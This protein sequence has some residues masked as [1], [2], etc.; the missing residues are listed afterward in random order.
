MT[1]TATIARKKQPENKEKKKPLLVVRSHFDLLG[2]IY[3]YPI[4]LIGGLGVALLF[5]KEMGIVAGTLFGVEGTIANILAFIILF[6]CLYAEPIFISFYEYKK[7]PFFF[8][9]D[10]LIFKQSIF[11]RD[12]VQME[13]KAIECATVTQNSIQKQNNLGHIRLQIRDHGF[14]RA[15]DQGHELENIPNPEEIAEKINQIIDDYYDH[16][17]DQPHAKPPYAS[18]KMQALHKENKKD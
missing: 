7:H 8:Y 9:D 16:I 12:R 14:G 10:R 15:K 3:E 13:Y 6:G 1:K 17:Y 11:L 18:K 4:R 2:R 5:L